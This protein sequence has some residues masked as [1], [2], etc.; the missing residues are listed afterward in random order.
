MKYMKAQLLFLT[1][2]WTTPWLLSS[3]PFEV[4]AGSAS[5]AIEEGKMTVSNSDGA[6]LHWPKFSIPKN[7]Q[8]HFEQNYTKSTVFNQVMGEEKSM[9]EGILSSNGKV[10]LINPYGIH[11][12]PSALV[13][14]AGFIAST[15][16][17]SLWE[18]GM[19]FDNPG[20]GS[21]VNEGTIRCKDYEVLLV[22]KQIDNRGLCEGSVVEML[23]SPQILLHPSGKKN[24]YLDIAPADSQDTPY[25]YAIRHSGRI[26]ATSILEEN[27]QVFLISHPGTTHVSGAITAEGGTVHILGDDVLLESSAFIDVSGLPGGTILVGGD[28]G[29][30]NPE[31]LNAKQTT[32]E[33]GAILC[34]KGKGQSDGGR[35][36]YWSDGVTMVG[37]KT[38]VSSGP[39]GGD[40]GFI[41]VSGKES[42]C[43]RGV[44]D[45]RAPFGSCGT[46]L[47]DP[48]ADITIS[49]A[50]DSNITGAPNY[51]P[52]DSPANILVA[53]VTSL[54]TELSMGNV[55]ITTNGPSVTMAGNGDLTFSSNVTW[56]GPGNLTCTVGRDCI[57]NGSIQN[58]GSTGNVVINAQ[59]RI[60][61]TANIE[62]MGGDIFLT[63]GLGFPTDTYNAVDTNSTPILSTTLN[64]RISITG[65]SG[66]GAFLGVEL[67]H[68]VA[69]STAQG[70][71]SIT[72]SCR[73]TS[74][75][76]NIGVRFDATT[77]TMD[78]NI[79]VIGTTPSQSPGSFGIITDNAN[80][81]LATIS[82]SGSI[83]VRG[84]ALA[85]VGTSLGFEGTNFETNT[86]SI[87][88]EGYSTSNTGI[89]VVFGGPPAISTSG[90]IRWI[91]QGVPAILVHRP[92]DPISTGGPISIQT[93]GDVILQP[94]NFSNII[95]S[96]TGSSPFTANI[97]GNLLLN[98]TLGN[99]QIGSNVSPA[100]APIDIQ[101]TGN[102]TL[103]GP[104][105][106]YA[107]IGHG[108]PN[109]ML[110]SL[111][112]NIQV[113]AGGDIQLTGT[114]GFTQIGHVSST[115][116]GTTIGGN[117]LVSAGGN[118]TLTDNGQY[119][120]IGSGGINSAT[121]LPSTV[122][123]LAGV[124]LISNAGQMVNQNG[125]LT[126]V[127]DN[128]Y[129]SP[130][131]FGSG[132]LYIGPGSFVSSTGELRLYSVVQNQNTILA[133]LNGFTFT[134][135][136]F[137]INTATEEWSI[138]Y[139]DGSYG[140]TPFKFYYKLPIIGFV[141]DKFYENIAANLTAMN[142]L[143]PILRAE[144]LPFQFPAYL[145]KVCYLY[146]RPKD[147]QID[148]TRKEPFDCGPTLA[149]YGSFIFEDTVWWV[150]TSF[151]QEE[152]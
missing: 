105:A 124:N 49:G 65:T 143:L 138:Y 46:I 131:G 107:L 2:L 144:R 152:E 72:G 122:N 26:A 128:L 25:A 43:Y 37:S 100:S 28:A 70:D 54:E 126:L 150:G 23:S 13:E 47:F 101:V 97:Q 7:F 142:N 140:A 53:G 91:A 147:L 3:D 12:S 115:G 83:S 16:D 48:E 24:I 85:G 11:F 19:L 40:G 66:L 80:P 35:V 95:F 103:I 34:A 67:S 117:I 45:R 129:P 74:N 44:S 58:T 8:V 110:A 30:Q 82:G 114:Q 93:I 77:T 17:L 106:N 6:L 127:A 109:A 61:I 22:S 145:A 81:S 137:N 55:T 21:I 79:T 104:T 92:V 36:I 63:G 89:Q 108:D 18:E 125:P 130:Y 88:I 62:L 76:N 41:E 38:D 94:S 141:L 123:I 50:M 120:R 102:I 10:I 96:P 52:T 71:I 98:A 75:V 78:G 139:P 148:Q 135:G 39:D 51:V 136:P 5:C 134:P 14:T 73:D 4:A 32:V 57:I 87:T 56:N 119:A 69:L 99:I 86:G 15:L 112:G 132:S 118:I 116:G 149:P 1:A 111:T 133:P 84:T 9:L 59:R 29:G 60:H 27:G 121:F 31:V 146:L 20:S 68:F 151:I 42:F 64:G 113:R 90:A 33:S